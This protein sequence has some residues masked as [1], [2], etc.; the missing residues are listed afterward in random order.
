M[1]LF[2]STPFGTFVW[3]MWC[4][5]FSL[6]N[7]HTTDIWWKLC[8]ATSYVAECWLGLNLKS[9]PP[10]REK[11]ETLVNATPRPSYFLE[12]PIPIVQEAGW[13]L[14]PI[15]TCVVNIA[16]T[17]IRLASRPTN[18]AIIMWSALN[19]WP[20]ATKRS[21]FVGKW[22][23]V[24]SVLWENPSAGNQNGGQKVIW[25]SVKCP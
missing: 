8:V 15:W 14:G 13:A 19:S 25:S 10:Q 23:F 9:Y 6:G 4:H 16:P 11:N 18:W 7:L 24:L 1:T 3:L 20:T 12:E 2:A 5:I 21:W 22:H 17:G